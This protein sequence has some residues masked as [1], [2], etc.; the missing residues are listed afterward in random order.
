MTPVWIVL[1]GA[2]IVVAGVLLLRLHALL[3]LTLGALAVAALTPSGAIRRYEIEKRAVVIEE[4]ELIGNEVTLETLS[5]MGARARMRYD[6]LR[7][8]SK[9]GELRPIGSLQIVTVQELPQAKGKKR[10]RVIARWTP[11]AGDAVPQPDDLIVHP[12]AVS[13]AAKVS[14]TTIGQR[15]A[16]GFGATCTKIGILIAMAA[17]IGKCLLDSGAADRIVRS[18][19][20]LLGQRGAPAA[21]LGSGFLLGIPVFFDTVFYLMIPLGKALATVVMITG[22]SIIAVPT[23][24]FTAEL[25]NAMRQDSLRHNCPTCDKLTHEPNA[26]F[27]SRC[28]SQLFEPREQQTQS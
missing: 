18:A 10:S 7:R 9:S 15:V 24:I 14:R 12:L 16:T 3:A 5:R 28:G 1:A 27:C 20:G 21:F 25:A 11:E 6:V 23:G 26:A 17:I 13:E 22:Y 4:I 19:L 2:G 8:D